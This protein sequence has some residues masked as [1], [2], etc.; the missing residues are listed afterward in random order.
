[1][2]LRKFWDGTLWTRLRSARQSSCQF[3]V[4]RSGGEVEWWT[5]RVEEW[6]SRIEGW[7]LEYRSIEGLECWRAGVLEYLGA[8]V[9]SIGISSKTNNFWNLTD[10]GVNSQTSPKCLN[11]NENTPYIP[12]SNGKTDRSHLTYISTKLL[13]MRV[14][15]LNP[16]PTPTQARAI[17]R[18]SITHRQHGSVCLTSDSFDWETNQYCK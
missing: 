10:C 17:L 18:A 13:R 15:L 1:M 7:V 14:L 11:W 2:A 6:R 5:G 12:Y 16:S 8:G 9:I 3:K 4:E